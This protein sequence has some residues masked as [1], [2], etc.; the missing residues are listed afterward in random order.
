MIRTLLVPY[1]HTSIQVTYNIQ[2]TVR[3]TVVFQLI[4][5]H[6]ERTQLVNSLVHN[7]L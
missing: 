7:T 4:Q 6:T 2:V 3:F 1:S 5:Y